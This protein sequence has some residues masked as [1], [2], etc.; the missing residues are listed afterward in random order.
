MH[1]VEVTLENLG[2]VPS[3][4]LA[5]VFWELDEDEP[6]VDARFEK[7]EWFSSTLLE[8]G[9]CA[10]LLLDGG[11]ARGF[12]E[13]AP[14]A[15]FPRLA[16]FRC[17]Q[18]SG[19]AIYLSYCYLVPGQRGRG[20]GTALVGSV[21]TDLRERGYRALEAIGDREWAGDWVLPAGFL[22]ASGFTVIR[23]DSRFPLMR[24]ELTS[25][26]EPALHAGAVARPGA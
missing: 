22:A 8:W 14:P 20:W 3:E 24:L 17:G 1:F 11:S 10:K 12:V 13:Y 7:E 25:R 19:D 6:P 16:K 21:A 23:E 26:E 2:T 9:P 5:S 18:A 15:L 4:V